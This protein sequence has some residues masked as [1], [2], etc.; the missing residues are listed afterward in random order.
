MAGKVQETKWIAFFNK[1]I[2]QRLTKG[3]SSELA[4]YDSWYQN[5]LQTSFRARHF[6][7]GPKNTARNPIA[8]FDPDTKQIV[9]Q[10]TSKASAKLAILLLHSLGY[11]CGGLTKSN[12]SVVLDRAQYPENAVFGYQWIPTSLLRS[13]DFRVKK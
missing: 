12:A 10:Y 6:V 9:K 7:V 8:V 5:K 4:S 2:A 3:M 13:G 1:Y 11:N